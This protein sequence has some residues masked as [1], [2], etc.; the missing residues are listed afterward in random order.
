MGECVKYVDRRRR[1]AVFVV[2][3][4][5]PGARRPEMGRRPGSYI[6]SPE[7]TSFTGTSSHLLRVK[8]GGGISTIVTPEPPHHPS[9]RPL[10]PMNGTADDGNLLSL[11]CSDIVP[12]GD[13]T[14]PLGPT[15]LG[16][17]DGFQDED[18]R[19]PVVDVTE[20][21]VGETT[22]DLVRLRVSSRLSRGSQCVVRHSGGTATPPRLRRS[23]GSSGLPLRRGGFCV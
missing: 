11:R 10:D 12:G 4:G 7:R 1:T 9:S 6:T 3:G 14:G 17:D 19:E 13:K 22:N 20:G 2:N 21:Q 16:F 5:P 18:N 8:L 15:Q 23:L